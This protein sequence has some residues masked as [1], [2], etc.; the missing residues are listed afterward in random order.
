MTPRFANIFSLL[1][2][3]YYHFYYHYYASVSLVLKIQDP[4]V[5]V[6]WMN[7]EPVTQSE[8]SQEEKNKYRIWVHI[9]G[10]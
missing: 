3:C 4:L 9:Y 10:V 1:V 8:V 5:L 2:Y 6:R 7:L